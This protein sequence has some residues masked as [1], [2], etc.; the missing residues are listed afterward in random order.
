MQAEVREARL[1]SGAEQAPLLLD[2]FGWAFVT[3]L[4]V[5]WIYLAIPH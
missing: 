5:L 2:A 1:P 4:L 3:G